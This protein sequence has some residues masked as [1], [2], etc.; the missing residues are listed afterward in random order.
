MVRI[1]GVVFGMCPILHLKDGAFVIGLINIFRFEKVYLLGT[2]ARYDNVW[3]YFP[4]YCICHNTFAILKLPINSVSIVTFT[5][6]IYLFP[7]VL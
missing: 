3:R 4:L 6:S 5:I 1:E 2:F 7:K